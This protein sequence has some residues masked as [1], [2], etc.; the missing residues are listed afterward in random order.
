MSD[1]F[2]ARERGALHRGKKAEFKKKVQELA[3]KK[4]MEPKHY[5]DVRTKYPKEHFNK[6]STGNIG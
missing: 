4:L 3:K 6:R 1:N 5:E 2:T